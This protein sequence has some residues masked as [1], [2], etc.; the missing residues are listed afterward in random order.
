MS[1]YIGLDPREA[2]IEIRARGRGESSIFEIPMTAL[3]AVHTKALS[4]T[5]RERETATRFN[6]SIK[7]S[8]SITGQKVEFQVLAVYV[9]PNQWIQLDFCR[10]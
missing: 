7:S 1:F 5:F 10:I 9:E 2:K 4:D 8:S 3:D 6:E